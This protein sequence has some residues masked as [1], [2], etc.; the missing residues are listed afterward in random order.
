MAMRVAALVL[1]AGSSQRFGGRPKQFEELGGTTVL[2][3]A[4]RAFTE[5]DEIAETWVVT[6]AEHRVRTADL[7]VDE[8]IAGVIRGGDSRAQSTQLGLAALDPAVSH[9]IIH[10]AARPLVPRH[11]VLDCLAAFARADVVATVVEPPDSVVI[12]D[13]HSIAATPDRSNVRLY[14]TPQA[15]RCSLLTAAWERLA[16]EQEGSPTDDVTAVLKAFPD[17]EVAWVTGHR[18]SAKI[19]EPDDLA[20]LRSWVEDDE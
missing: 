8:G 12:L 10:D 2:Q 16:A 11:V 19:T 5:V 14:Q 4:V 9:V 3:H 20:M 1:A 7:L 17:Q 6:S 13:G 18:R 15:F